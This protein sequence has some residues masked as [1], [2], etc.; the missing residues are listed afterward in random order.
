[1]QNLLSFLKKTK[2]MLS[3]LLMCVCMLIG[4]K[5]DPLADFPRSFRERLQ[6]LADMELATSNEDF[7]PDIQ[8]VSEYFTQIIPDDGVGVLWKASTGETFQT[9]LTVKVFNIE[10]EKLSDFIL[11]VDEFP[12][13]KG[14]IIPSHL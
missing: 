3:C 5:Q 2:Q 12:P 11:D 6:E 1:M 7:N 14:K 4:C 10:E 8:E 13:L 9:T